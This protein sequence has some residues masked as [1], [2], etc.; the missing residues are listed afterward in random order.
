MSDRLQEW[1]RYFTVSVAVCSFLAVAAIAVFDLGLSTSGAQ[2]LGI[3]GAA[4][5]VIIEAD[6]RDKLPDKGGSDA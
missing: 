4:S 2:I 1:V 3:L 6:R 5:W